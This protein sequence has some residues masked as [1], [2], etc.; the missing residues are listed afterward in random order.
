MATTP[1]VV[2]PRQQK[3]ARN[4]SRNV[5]SRWTLVGKTQR[6]T[7]ASIGLSTDTTFA[8]KILISQ[9]L[10]ALMVKFKILCAASSKVATTAKATPC[11]VHS[12]VSKC[13]VSYDPKARQID[14]MLFSRGFR[15]SCFFRIFSKVDTCPFHQDVVVVMGLEI[16]R[17][18]CACRV[19]GWS[20][21]TLTTL[22]HKTTY[23]RLL[24]WIDQ[25]FPHR[26]EP[27]STTFRFFYTQ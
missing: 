18:Q 22:K 9:R 3:I 27:V 13:K 23:H 26:A 7:N 19:G 4:S 1:K 14:K 17:S 16:C 6:A 2:A 20:M 21:I 24:G 5:P 15:G 10:P 25:G 12:M 8:S 11:S